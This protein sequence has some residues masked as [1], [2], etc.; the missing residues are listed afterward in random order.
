TQR[1]A[2]WD[3][4][5]STV[6]QI[7][8]R[9]TVVMCIDANGEMDGAL[10]WMGRA[11]EKRSDRNKMWNDNGRRFFEAI[12]GND[13]KAASTGGKANA[14]CW[15]RLSPLRKN[16]RIDYSAARG[17][18][19]NIASW[20][21][22]K[23]P[24]G[25]AGFRDH[26]PAT[27]KLLPRAK[28][29]KAQ[30]IAQTVVRWERDT[31]LRNMIEL[32]EYEKPAGTGANAAA[33]AQVSKAL[34]CKKAVERAIQ[35]GARMNQIEVDK[36][37]EH[38]KQESEGKQ[39]LLQLPEEIAI[40]I[41]K[42]HEAMKRMQGASGLAER[43]KCAEQFKV[44]R[45]QAKDGG[46]IKAAHE[47]IKR[48]ALKATASRAS[49]RRG[50]WLESRGG[51]GELDARRDALAH[52]FEAIPVDMGVER[53]GGEARTKATLADTAPKA[54]RD[55]ARHVSKNKAREFVGKVV[56]P[57]GVRQVQ[58]IVSDTACFVDDVI[59]F[60]AFCR[61]AQL[62]E[63]AEMV[64][65]VLGKGGPEV[66]AGKLELTVAAHGEGARKH[67]QSASK[68]R[69][70]ISFQGAQV[71]AVNKVKYLVYVDNASGTASV[72]AAARIAQAPKLERRQA[73]PLRHIAKPPAHISRETSD[74]LRARLGVHAGVAGKPSGLGKV[75]LE[76]PREGGSVA[77]D[78]IRR[79]PPDLAAQ[80]G[81]DREVEKPRIEP[82]QLRWL[83][84]TSKET[85]E[86]LQTTEGEF[87][88]EPEQVDGETC[89]DCGA[90]RRG[91]N[92]DSN[93]SDT[94]V[95]DARRK[96]K[97][98]ASVTPLEAAAALTLIREGK[99]RSMARDLNIVF[100]MKKDS[101]VAIRMLKGMDEH[102]KDGKLA[103]EAVE[104][105]SEEFKG[106]PNSKKQDA[107]LRL[108][109][110]NAA[111]AISEDVAPKALAAARQDPGWEEAAKKALD[112]LQRA[113]QMGMVQKDNPALRATRCF[114]VVVEADKPVAKWIW[115]A[116]GA[117]EFAAMAKERKGAQAPRIAD[118]E[119]AK[120]GV[121]QSR[122]AKEVKELLGSKTGAKSKT[123]RKY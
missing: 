105:Q 104:T 71:A 66:N 106:N 94:A 3:T 42:K 65:R 2:F 35:G 8:R 88:E 77:K 108:L 84:G 26:R 44:I 1:Y 93:T 21:D 33:A 22:Y 80:R 68:G 97:G 27:A 25:V 14:S 115:A 64:A 12:K 102:A 52:V 58:R 95:G 89:P 85:V 43:N 107:L 5:D 113:N 78:A 67:N 111:A 6:R 4:L 117:P 60:P 61:V 13:M 76:G 118:I 55:M 57:K 121:P 73:K 39:A 87:A 112:V 23:M 30:L 24:V 59:S 70:A 69:V 96:R 114:S 46:R 116:Q 100:Q 31:M 51:V 16:H 109:P 86:A 110:W 28:R 41:K 122:P 120:D 92:G 103:R 50:I 62:T 19:A 29:W 99:G 34:A 91:L 75:A 15:T 38:Y 48:L 17:I 9:A 56:V 79:R 7:P 18:T 47:Q 119:V 53:F 49:A 72:E 36:A 101:P 98:R 63:F 20:V 90:E 82:T 83:A 45:A 54:V 123:V 81:L 32:K 37:V 10:P 40:N 11:D 74:D